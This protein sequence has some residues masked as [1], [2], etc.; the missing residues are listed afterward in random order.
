MMHG[1]DGMINYDVRLKQ[2]PSSDIAQNQGFTAEG[3]LEDQALFDRAADDFAPGYDCP[4]LAAQGAQ[5]RKLRAYLDS[6]VTGFNAM[7]AA[8]RGWGAGKTFYAS[9]SSVYG[10]TPDSKVPTLSLTRSKPR[11]LSM[12]QP[13]KF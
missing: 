2:T 3:P 7:E 10:A 13:K 9:T 4:H 6:N 12:R 11:C 8:R 1:F 5:A